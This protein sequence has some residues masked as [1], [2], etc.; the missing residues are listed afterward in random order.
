[1]QPAETEAF[2][3]REIVE[4]IPALR[5]FARSLCR[6]SEDADD[7][8]QETLTKAISK[9][10]SY[11]AGTR[12][13]SWLFTIMRN[14]FCTRHRQRRREIVG[15]CAEVSDRLAVA[16]DQ[17]WSVQVSDVKARLD[18]LPASQRETIV[19]VV[20]LGET[21]ESA[22]E[23][24]GCSVG[25]IKSR[26][27]RARHGLRQRLEIGPDD[28]TYGTLARATPIRDARFPT[29]VRS[30]RSSGPVSI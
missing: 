6:H 28:P 8:V 20:M 18:E 10:S 19:L 13:K 22:A 9:A 30:D 27:N 14:T 1:M 11:Q 15:I 29:K 16:A 17:E 3:R 26:L 21:Y 7:L 2:K 12:L 25:T 23:I 24:L 5:A 4:H